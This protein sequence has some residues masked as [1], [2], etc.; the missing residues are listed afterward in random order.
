MCFSSAV[1]L[2][3]IEPR[4]RQRHL[5]HGKSFHASHR[6]HRLRLPRLLLLA[7]FLLVALVAIK[8]ALMTTL[9]VDAYQTR[10][11]DLRRGHM[12]DQL[13][14]VVLNVDPV[15]RAVAKRVIWLIN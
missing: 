4:R 1:L 6:R 11:I 15:T 5:P 13:A 7:V 10:L 14:A 9:G 2:H 8:V 3:E 12:V